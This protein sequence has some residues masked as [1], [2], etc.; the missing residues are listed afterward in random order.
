MQTRRI[1]ETGSN[2]GPVGVDGTERRRI[3]SRFQ[4][5]RTPLLITLGIALLFICYTL[6]AFFTRNHELTDVVQ[7]SGRIEADETRLVAASGTRVNNVYVKEGDVVHKGQLLVELDS[8]KLETK[9]GSASKAVGQARYAEAQANRQVQAV[10][11]EINVAK[12]KS[13]GFWTKVFTSPSGRKQKESELRQRMMQAKM[14]SFQAKSMAAQAQS[15]KSTAASKVSY[16]K[17]TSPIDGIVTTRSVEPGELVGQGQVLITVI[18]PQSVYMRG[19]IPEG[20]L[21]RVKVGQKAKV[22]LDSEK[23]KPL[24]GK[25]TTIDPEPS[26]TPQNVYFK[27]DRIRQSFGLKISLDHPDGIAKPGMK[28]DA[29]ILLNPENK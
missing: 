20:D 4:E 17:L 13:N 2:D 7:L 28:A 14:M 10:Q 16:F 21:A 27:D 23:V 18:D 8:D 19:F 29:K 3:S 9:I 26:F 25:L 15:L 5:F 1:R 12:K 6:V 24:D 11:Q 22:Y